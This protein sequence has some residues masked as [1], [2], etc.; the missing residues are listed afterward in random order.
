LWCTTNGKGDDAFS[1]LKGGLEANPTSFLLNFSFSEY[2]EQAMVALQ[3]TSGTDPKK[4]DEKKAE[5]HEHYKKFISLLRKELDE[6]EE[7]HISEGGAPVSQQPAGVPGQSMVA[8]AA[9]PLNVEDDIAMKENEI[10][11]IIDPA[12]TEAKEREREREEENKRRE[13][14]LVDK[15]IELGQVSI[16]WM[17]YAKRVAQ[18][19]GL[20]NVF[21]EV[22]ADKWV[23]WQ[24][25][26]AAGN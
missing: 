1:F 2:Q 5:G 21:K 10:Y 3:T 19:A 8:R 7:K 26:E 22:R 24:V 25:F 16:A 17:R 4:I 20:R 14:I 11:G 12:I 23:C 13:M 6:I 9:T 15:R 18:S